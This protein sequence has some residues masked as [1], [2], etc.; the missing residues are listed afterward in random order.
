MPPAARQRDEIPVSLVPHPVSRIQSWDATADLSIITDIYPKLFGMTT[1]ELNIVK[2]DFD[3]DRKFDRRDAR[4]EFR[5][6]A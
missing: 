4:S 6:I 2:S 5:I 1:R 3:S